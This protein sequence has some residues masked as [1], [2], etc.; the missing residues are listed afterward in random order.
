M[1]LG[2][3]VT[4]RKQNKHQTN[5][6][7][8]ILQNQRRPDRLD[9]M[10]RSCWLVE[11]CT[12]NLFLLDKL[13]INNFIWRRWKDYAIAYGKNDQKYGAAVIGSFTTTMPLPTLPWVCSSFWQKTIWRLSLILPIHPTLRHA[14]F[15]CSLVWNAR[16]KGNVLLMSA[17]WKRKRWRSWTTS[18]LKS[19]RNVFS[20]VKNVGTNVSSQKESALRE[21][22]VVIVQNLINH[23][24]MYK[25]YYELNMEK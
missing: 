22:T 1:R 11:L 5:G 2:A 23:L 10:L 8:L 19:S 9:Q 7:L 13:R 14:T 20:S 24:K 17:K 3:T 16:W 12:R 21:T 18:A 15:S 4:T 6:K 25:K